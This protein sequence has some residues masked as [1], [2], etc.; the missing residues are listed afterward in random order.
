MSGL[1][2]GQSR[3]LRST[4]HQLE[5]ESDSATDYGWSCC[6]CWWCSIEVRCYHLYHSLAAVSHKTDRCHHSSSGCCVEGHFQLDYCIATLN[7]CSSDYFH[8]AIRWHCC[9]SYCLDHSF[10]C[11]QRIW[12]RC[13]LN[14]PGT[15]T[16]HMSSMHGVP[17]PNLCNLRKLSSNYNEWCSGDKRFTYPFRSLAILTSMKPSN[18]EKIWSISSF[19]RSWGKSHT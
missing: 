1:S 9:R 4:K 8:F 10:C 6:C 12:H 17:S 3:S 19:S 11:D 14:I 13:P 18:S 5:T 16:L 2:F 15:W 7:C